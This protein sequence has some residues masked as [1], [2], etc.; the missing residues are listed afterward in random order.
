MPS[1]STR[2][3]PMIDLV[4][5][6]WNEALAKQVAGIDR[7]E[8]MDAP[9]L[10]RDAGGAGWPGLLRQ[11]REWR[12][13]RYDLAINLEG[14]VRSNILLSR[15]GARW[16]AGFGM[17]G[18]GP[19]LDDDVRFDPRSHTAVNG[20]RLVGAAFGEPPARQAWPVEGL[21]AAARLPQARLV[22]P[23]AAH[24]RGRHTASGGR[25]ARRRNARSSACTSAPDAR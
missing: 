24:A 23:P 15:A 10:A 1:G 2:R 21:D 14:D 12:A 20:V 13:R 8:T 4:V 5:G 25:R 18:G 17:A 19:L 22:V 7:V 3:T 6:S 11:A 9:W 16:C